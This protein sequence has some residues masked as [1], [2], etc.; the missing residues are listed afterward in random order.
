[1]RTVHLQLEELEARNLLSV[2]TPAQIRHAYGFDQL[3][4][5]NGRVQADGSGQ[6]IAIVEAFH[7]PKIGSDLYY[8]DWIFGLP[9]PPKFT[10]VNQRGGTAFTSVNPAWALETALDVEWGHAIAPKAN[11]LLVEADSANFNDLIAAV[12]FARYQP[13]VVV[14]S[15]SWGSREFSY[16]AAYDTY[17]TTPAG[18]IGGS[19][20]PGGITFVVS[21]G[22]DGH[23]TR[24]TAV[25]A[26]VL[27]V[28]GTS[29]ACRAAGGDG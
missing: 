14:V 6:T 1:M 22:G 9:D 21:S 20:L 24:Y 5:A 26:K 28:G 29:L 23:G 27:S 8:F 2:F 4:F 17:F 13:G 10:Q 12:N 16:E 11:I 7:D 15:M 25:S 18:H 3:S 19:G